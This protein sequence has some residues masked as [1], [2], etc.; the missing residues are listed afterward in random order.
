MDSECGSFKSVGVRGQLHCGSPPLPQIRA[1]SF[2]RQPT[3][4]P[5]PWST[6][7]WLCSVLSLWQC[8]ELWTWTQWNDWTWTNTQPFGDSFEVSS[9]AG[10]ARIGLG[11]YT[12]ATG[13][14]GSRQWST[15]VCQQHDKDCLVWIGLF[16]R[17]ACLV[18]SQ[19]ITRLNP[20]CCAHFSNSVPL[21]FAVL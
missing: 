5:K 7:S 2:S 4:Q 19:K 15:R 16:G 11:V 14:S 17:S 1:E 21:L 10:N 18:L 6:P 20:N 9:T 12:N 8:E 13:K 3:Y